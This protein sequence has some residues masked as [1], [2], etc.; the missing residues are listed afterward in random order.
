MNLKMAC[1]VLEETLMLNQE[2]QYLSTAGRG[3]QTP[4][5][6]A[7]HTVAFGTPEPTGTARVHPPGLQAP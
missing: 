1:F 4:I 5:L 3:P 6:L 7:K 2:Y